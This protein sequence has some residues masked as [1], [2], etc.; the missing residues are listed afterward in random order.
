[1]TKEKISG[2]YCIKNLKNSKCYIGLSV[3]ISHR[4]NSHRH[5]LRHNKHINKHLQNAWNKYGENNF[6]FS[7]LE[8]CPSDKLPQKEMYWIE[9]LNTFKN[10]YNS[11]IGGEGTFGYKFTDEQREKLSN[12]TKGRVRTSESIEKQKKTF[13][14]TL[15]NGYQIKTKHFQKYNKEKQRKI[16]CYIN[17]FNLYNIYESVHEASRDMDIPATRISSV[18]NKRTHNC[19]FNDYNI[20]TFF[21]FEETIS[22]EI[23]LNEFKYKNAHLKTKVNKYDE[24]NIL[25][26]TFSSVQ[27]CIKSDNITKKILTS[28]C[29]GKRNDKYYK[30]YTYT[31]SFE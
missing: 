11:S 3:D 24:N 18:L 10:G 14:Q 16:I 30:G 20:V 5:L 1:M 23:V 21:Y 31:Y 26:K 6:E 19:V 15:K 12:S 17:G 9:K 27:D 4:W 29:S 25:V 7:I 2:I 8:K 13:Q 28:I 22:E